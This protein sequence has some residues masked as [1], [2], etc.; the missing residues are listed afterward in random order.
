MS[1]FAQRVAE[2]I[3][4]EAHSGSGYWDELGGPDATLVKISENKYTITFPREYADDDDEEPTGE[5]CVITVES[6]VPS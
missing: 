5:S 1:S 3:D 4:C 6:S 2:Q